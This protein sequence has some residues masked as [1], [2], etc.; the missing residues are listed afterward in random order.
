MDGPEVI[1]SESPTFDLVSTTISQ[2]DWSEFSFVSLFID[3]DN[4][5]DG[6][7]CM[8]PTDGLS[9]ML[10]VARIQYV[11][12]TAPDQPSVFLPYFDAYLKGNLDEL[13]ALIY[14]AKRKGLSEAQV[15]ARRREDDLP[16]R[17]RMLDETI[18]A[19]A[20]LFDQ[21]QYAS[22]ISGLTPFE[23]LLPSVHLKKLELARRRHAENS[24]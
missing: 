9:V 13:F 12:E 3:D 15:V 20:L 21:K 24:G 17:Q 2:V 6:S 18:A 10:S 8:N 7:G 14:D 16:Q 22:Y 1:V 11:S 5:L 23:D 19:S 4:W